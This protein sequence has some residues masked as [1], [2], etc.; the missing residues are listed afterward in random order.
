M[1]DI[2]RYEGRIASEAEAE[3][4]FPAYDTVAPFKVGP[5]EER[6]LSRVWL[7]SAAY[8]CTSL[9]LSEGLIGGLIL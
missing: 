9:P 6:P 3:A 4:E 7:F 8:L 5:G 2:I 1:S